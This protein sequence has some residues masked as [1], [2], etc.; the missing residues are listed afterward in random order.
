MALNV[1]RSVQDAFYRY[2]MPR[3]Q[4]KVEGKGNGVKTVIP[5]MVEIARALGRPP[6]YATKYFGCELGAQTQFDFKNERYIVNGSHDAAKL[7][8]M[9]DGFIKKFVLCEKCDNPE[10]DIKAYIKKGI[11]TASCRACG[12][13]FQL[14]MR[15]KLTTYMLKNPPGTKLNDTGTS[16][17]ERKEK[18]S[19][20]RSEKNDSPNGGDNGNTSPMN[21]SNEEDDDDDNWTV[22]TSEDAIKARQVEGLS[23]GIKALA[24]D[25]DI[26]KTE[27]E[28]LDIFEKFVKSKLIL[29]IETKA[30]LEVKDEKEIV[31]EAER[32]EVTNKAPIVLCVL[33]FDDKKSIVAQI[34]TYRRLMLRF[35]HENQKAQ[36][37]LMGGIEKTIE[38]FKDT[39]L[40]KTGGILKAFFDHDILDEEV[41]TEWGKKV[42]KKYVSKD[43]SEQIHKKAE[44]FL[45][46]LKEAEE[47]SEDEDDE[48][49]LQ[50]D[51][52]AKNSSIKQVAENGNG[53][54]NSKESTP[55]SKADEEEDGAD[56]VDIDDI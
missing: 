16:L 39:F 36:K 2:K 10:T 48:V 1:N 4:A 37:Y 6:T 30:T 52:R 25:D 12:H 31:T 9:L 54:K 29:G 45:T 15:H 55:A 26:E 18:K 49:E 32:L 41:I 43:L 34:K 33:L 3:L 28:R 11:L 50:F 35:C 47:E 42:S 51:E 13:T 20:L 24:I 17:T 5:N 22:D 46:W 8:D 19:K 7:Q 40:A 23:Q 44:P 27:G 56:D 38:T 21:G 14:D 53:N